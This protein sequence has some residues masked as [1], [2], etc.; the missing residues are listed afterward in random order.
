[1]TTT[2]AIL[3]ALAS[4]VALTNMSGL[5]GAWLRRRCGE[6]VGFSTLPLL[7]LACCGVAWIL[8]PG[9]SLWVFVPAALDPGTWSLLALPASL[10]LRSRD[11]GDGHRSTRPS[12]DP[13]ARHAVHEFVSEPALVR[14]LVPL[15][16]AKLQDRYI[17]HATAEHYYLPDELADRART[18]AEFILRG[19]DWIARLDAAQTEAA[20]S[21]AKV[22]LALPGP[23]ALGADAAEMIENPR[24]QELRAEA[25][26]LLSRLGYDVAALEEDPAFH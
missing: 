1:M 20:R 17:R 14:R 22:A 15:A 10:L 21:F 24:W 8:A 3:V 19:E 25:A 11:A 2:A 12:A 6:E 13:A 23:E 9:S 18:A 5:A 7:S 4:L 16:S 26:A